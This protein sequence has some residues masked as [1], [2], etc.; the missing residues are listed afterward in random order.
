M[1]E[2]SCRFS[3]TIQLRSSHL[4][5]GLAL[6]RAAN[7][8]TPTRRATEGTAQLRQSLRRL[9]LADHPS[10]CLPLPTDPPRSILIHS[11]MSKN[12]RSNT[13]G[14]PPLRVITYLIFAVG[15]TIQGFVPIVKAEQAS[16]PNVVLVTADDLG[17][18]LGCYGDRTVPT[19]N[20]DALAEDGVLFENAYATSA[21]C[22]PS[23][24]TFLTGLYPHQSGQVGLANEYSMRP[25]IP[26]LTTWLGAAGYYTAL[27]GKL[28][29]RPA[30]DFHFD[31]HYARKFHVDTLDV[32]KMATQL[33]GAIRSAGNRPVF[34]Y[35]NYFDPHRNP[36]APDGRK[37]FDRYKG[38]P[39]QTASPEQMT[40][41]AFQGFTSDNLKSEAAGYYNSVAR[42][43]AGI[44]RLIKTLKAEG[45]WKDT[46]FIFVSDNGPDF[47]RAKGTCYEAGLRIPLVVKFPEG[48]WSGLKV[49]ALVSGID[50]VPTILEVVGQQTPA[51][52]PGRSLTALAAGAEPGD[53]ELLFGEA[54]ATRA[55]LGLYPVRSVR[56]SRFKLINN[57]QHM[58][59]NPLFQMAD[60]AADELEKQTVPPAVRNA[61]SRLRNPPEF[62]LYDLHS[63]PHEFEDLSADPKYAEIARDLQNKLNRWRKQSGD[64]I[65]SQTRSAE[66]EVPMSAAHEGATD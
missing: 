27:F 53:R 59:Q 26:N 37:F 19:P 22:S 61:F 36:A 46:L 42:L 2:V 4:A 10:D 54:T 52:L 34:L 12:S 18:Q 28:H 48:K 51:D 44:G 9:H 65:T 30:A 23:R 7:R 35:I 24:S 49:T 63:D 40:P 29:V 21:L 62:E 17:L 8:L 45:R 32:G 31:A 66:I 15:C 20:I 43:D 11:P 14:A 16:A 5:R 57:L 1:L 3:S 47:T 41:F 60:R 13:G 58:R 6:A 50:L 39:E 38:Y 33:A 56:D 64:P 55:K 25:G